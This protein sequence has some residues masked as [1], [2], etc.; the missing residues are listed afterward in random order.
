MA[1]HRGTVASGVGSPPS[2]T[3]SDTTN[4]NQNIATFN[5][6]VSANY[7]TT[8]TIKFQ[9]STNN[10]TWS[11]ATGGTTIANTSSQSVSVY[12]NA[13][14][15]SVGTF[16]YVRLVA[17]N[18]VGT[19]I[20]TASTGNFTTWGVQ[21][22]QRDSLGGT[23][24]TIPTVTPTGGS[25]VAVSI[26][27][28]IMFGGGGGGTGNVGGGGGGYQSVSSRA[29]SGA[30]SVTTYVGAGGATTDYTNG[31]NS[32]AGGNTTITGDLTSLTANGGG[33]DSANNN[34]APSSGN[35][36][37]GGS[38][39]TYDYT[40]GDSKGYTNTA[41]GGAG[42]AGAV[43]VNGTANSS[44]TTGGNGGAGVSITSGGVTIAGGAGGGSNALGLDGGP[45]TYGVQGANNSYGSGGNFSAAGQV[46]F[47]R[48]RYY[49]A[50]ALA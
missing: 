6:T 1:L 12:Y 44:G 32:T 14:G 25:A 21:V 45:V 35:S 43:G 38:N 7:V 47:I 5:G 34:I 30:R 4:F 37:A 15:L 39:A 49:A 40:P 11:D 20:T 28:I 48:F 50:S 22:Y 24:F 41:Y 2:V 23:T 18:S 19:S 16:Y 42:G 8:T 33:T 31:I 13:T 29:L 46:G 36:N 9:V 10:S 17:T 27:D 26:F 3:I